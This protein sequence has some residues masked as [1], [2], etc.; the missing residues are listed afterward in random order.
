MSVAKYPTNTLKKRFSESVSLGRLYH[1]TGPEFK[2]QLPQLEEDLDPFIKHDFGGHED[3]V[4]SFFLLEPNGP[5]L[6]G[7]P[8]LKIPILLLQAAFFCSI[9]LSETNA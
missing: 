9:F 1:N 7:I 6:F 4:E 2:D 5:T 3:K 8:L